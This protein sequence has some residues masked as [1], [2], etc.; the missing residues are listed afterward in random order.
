MPRYIAKMKLVK[1]ESDM[2]TTERVFSLWFPAR[3]ANRH[4]QLFGMF[5]TNG[6]S[7]ILRSV[8]L[9]YHG[10]ALQHPHRFLCVVDQFMWM[11]QMKC[12]RRTHV[13]LPVAD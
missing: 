11:F 13:L 10:F 12:R 5:G 6:P 7:H 4:E 8:A 2:T 1:K 3:M 9:M